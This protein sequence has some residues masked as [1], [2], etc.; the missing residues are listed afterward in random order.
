MLQPSS[1][2]P[3]RL[4]VVATVYR[5]LSHAQHFCDRFMVGYPYEGRWNMPNTKVVSMYV[6]QRPV[7]DQSDDRAREFG[8]DVYPTVAEALR[9]GG[10]ELAVDGVLLIGEH[11]DYPSNEL[12]QILYPR[13]ELFKECVEVFEADGRSVAIYNDKH[14]SYSF[15]KAQEMVE[16]AARLDFPLLAGSSLPVTYRLPDLELPYGCQ[17]EEAMMLGVGGSDAM[18][19]HALEAMQCM[20]ERRSGS[21]TGV[22]AVQMLE[23]DDV[24]RAADEGRWSTRLVEAAL[25]RSDSPQG[26]SKEDGRTQDLLGSG[27]LR[28][29]VEKPVAYLI[30]FRDGLRATLLMINGAI[31]DYN[32]AAKLKGEEDPVSCQFFLTPTP[33]VTYSAC[34]A[35]KIDEMFQTGVAPFPAQRTMIVNGIL[36]SCLQSRHQGSKRLETPHLEV[37]YTAPEASHYS[38][39]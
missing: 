38:R 13:Y 14:L 1:D 17:I 6:D 19:Y 23:G 22:A 36:E 3:K 35:A 32:F 11:G 21:E 34:F 4:A 10:D 9:C 30:E 15:A 33:N 16:D 31:G 26:L 12:G 25:S 37:G 7:G 5:Y 27:E 39:A 8:F 28:R 29:L 18:D 2:A 20:I 24:W